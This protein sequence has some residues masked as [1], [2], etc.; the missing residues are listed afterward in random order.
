MPPKFTIVL[1]SDSTGNNGTAGSK[2]YSEIDKARDARAAQQMLRH[3]LVLA[4][5]GVTSSFRLRRQGPSETSQSEVYSGAADGRGSQ[6]LWSSTIFDDADDATKHVS[7]A[8]TAPPPSSTPMLSCEAVS[9]AVRQ[10][11]RKGYAK[12]LYDD[13]LLRTIDV[14]LRKAAEWVSLQEGTRTA[15]GGSC[16]SVLRRTTQLWESFTL[17]LHHIAAVFAE[18][19]QTQDASRMLDAPIRVVGI[20]R[21]CDVLMRESHARRE[22]F[23][24]GYLE[25]LEHDRRRAA[26]EASLSIA[27]N[28]DETLQQLSATSLNAAEPA[29]PL[30]SLQQIEDRALLQTAR[31]VGLESQIYFPHMEPVVV[32]QTR[33]YYER[34]AQEL[35]YVECLEA[36]AYFS[37]VHRTLNDERERMQYYLDSKSRS[38]VEEAAQQSLIA[39]VPDV[40]HKNFDA[41]VDRKQLPSIRLAWRLL[42]MRYVGKGDVARACFRDYIVRQGTSIVQQQAVTNVGGAAA[43]ASSNPQEESNVVITALLQLFEKAVDVVSSSFD[44]L[45]VFHLTVR[46][47]MQASMRPREH[48]VAE[49]LSRYLDTY[50]REGSRRETDEVVEVA[51][52]QCMRLFAFLPAKDIFEAFY[53]EALA[54]RLVFQRV[55]SLELERNVI[56]EIRSVTGSSN[57]SKLDGMLKDFTSQ[58]DLNS[59]YLAS[60]GGGGGSGGSEVEASSPT[61]P[62]SVVE[63]EGATRFAGFAGAQSVPHKIEA[64]YLVITNGLWP[65]FPRLPL[66]ISPALQACA[67]AFTAFYC[68]RHGGRKLEW[69]PTLATCVVR[70]RLFTGAPGTRREITMN[71]MQG[72]IL[73]LFERDTDVVSFEQ[74]CRRL[75]KTPG[76]W[77]AVKESQ[78]TI[79]A[80]LSIC[81]NPAQRL[82]SRNSSQTSST[83]GDAE[84]FSLNASFAHKSIKFRINQLQLKDT[85][86]QQKEQQESAAIQQK[87]LQDRAH[88]IDAAIV[89]YMKSRRRATHT[90]V[91]QDVLGM[92]K[93]PSSAADV[94]KR[95]EVLMEREYVRRDVQDPTM[96]EYVA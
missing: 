30:S 31:T 19:G 48:Y 26:S 58:E 8:A 29:A 53:A 4:A 47:A 77:L 40:L 78:D 93:F 57:S 88:V 62:H 60:V 3:L 80:I 42:S 9:I 2:M 14:F 74:I 41:L 49:L 59:E 91:V 71:L 27:S 87:A 16:I 12:M 79:C 5:E 21:F 72:M 39:L 38:R 96:F 66:A 86:A 52:M 56:R 28:S 51:V 55:R 22:D 68:R 46:E 67:D 1:K 63:V 23:V 17:S 13:V 24:K 43:A 50:L 54:K 81:S 25:L 6:P 15:A 65:Q 37:V 44:D 84:T 70:A 35:L 82:I 92:L 95:I 73:E 32:A 45:E 94:K 75:A 61:T 34:Y 18:L 85:K 36:D 69:L 33:A 89:R 11:V 10:L 90:D 20:R 7:E 64:K 83:I 76:D